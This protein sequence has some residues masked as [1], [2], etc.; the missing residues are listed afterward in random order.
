MSEREDR[1]RLQ[2]M[3]DASRQAIAFIQ[4]RGRKDL[5]ANL[6]LTLALTRLVEIVGEAAKNVS[7]DER[8]RHPEVPWR[9]IA[10]TRDRLVHAYF[11]V[12]LDQLWRIVSADLPALVPVLERALGIAKS[13]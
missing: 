7:D 12:D 11:D 10:G 9:A 8:R 5:D 4:G 2:H 1:V 6:Q 3:L 13:P